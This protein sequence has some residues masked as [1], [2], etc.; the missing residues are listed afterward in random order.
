MRCNITPLLHLKHQRRI[1]Y[2]RCK[3]EVDI[4]RDWGASHVCDSDIVIFEVFQRGV[5]TRGGSGARVMS[6][7]YGVLGDHLAR[8]W[9]RDGARLQGG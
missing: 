7:N 1:T 5:R 4:G 2:E 8:A 9:R 6:A 3:L